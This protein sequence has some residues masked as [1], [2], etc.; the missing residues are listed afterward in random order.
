M[1]EAKQKL[2]VALS[3]RLR[4]MSTR[5]IQRQGIAVAKKVLSSDAYRRA[6][7]VAV[8]LNM[9]KE[10]PTL[11]ILEDLLQPGSNKRCYV[12]KVD[13]TTST[14]RM[15]R[16]Y[17]KEDLQS[18]PVQKFKTFELIEPPLHFGSQPREEAQDSLDLIIVPGLGFDTKGGR[19][20]RGK[21]YYDQF[22]SKCIAASQQKGL[23]IPYLMAV[24]FN[25]QIVDD[26]PMLEYDQRMDEVVFVEEKDIEEDDFPTNEV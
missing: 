8:Y 5:E 18:F 10:L 19:L 26:I 11:A 25:N 21:G 14:M 15:L 7:S 16:V 4:K 20:G 3:A 22:L 17:S 2:R 6:T 9:P 1:Q 23:P 12:P 24:C 13:D